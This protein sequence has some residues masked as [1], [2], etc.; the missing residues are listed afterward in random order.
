MPQL[1][2]T[3]NALTHLPT[4]DRLAR[5]LEEDLLRRYGTLLPG[6]ALASELGYPSARAYQQAV[7]RRTVPV[8]VFQVPRRRGT[9]ALAKDVAEW[10]ALQRHGANDVGQPTQPRLANALGQAEQRECNEKAEAVDS[11]AGLTSHEET[12]M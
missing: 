7:T 8:P 2:A 5:E 10:V 3:D 1:N 12:A 11:V 6:S 9:F 4:T